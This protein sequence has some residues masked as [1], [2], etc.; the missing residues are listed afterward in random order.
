MKFDAIIFDLDGTLLNTLFDLKE[1]TNFVLGKY[2]Y[3]ERTIEEVR[4]FVGNGV[5][6]LIERALPEGLKNPL[7]EQCLMDFKNDYKTRMYEHTKPY[8]GILRMLDDINAAGIKTA[9]VSN[10]FDAAVKELCKIS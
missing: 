8:D 4:M 10:K 6:K 9:V 3:P 5:A 7:Y 2:G 1:S